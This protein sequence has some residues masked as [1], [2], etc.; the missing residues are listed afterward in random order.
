[1]VLANASLKP[2]KLLR[3][4]ETNHAHYKNRNK[5]FFLRK[6]HEFKENKKNI[7]SFTTEDK[8]Y[9][10]CS[11]LVAM[12][13]AKSKKAYTIGEKLLKPCMIDIF[14]ELFGSEYATKIN[15]IPMSNDT[16]S[17]RIN[18]MAVDIEYQLIQKIK[19]SIFYGIQIDE[20]TD[21]NNE[22]I[23]L[24]YIRYVDTDLN[25]I[26]EEFLCCLNLPSFC[27]SEEIFKAILMYFDKNDLSISK[28]IGIC[29]DGAAAM[30]RKFNGLVARIKQIAHK[31]IISTHCF[32]HREQLATKDMGENLFN[33]LN[34]CIK[35]INFIRSSAVNTRIFKVM[36][37]EMGSDYTSLLLHTHVRWLSRGKCLTRLFEL[38]T[39]VEIFLKDKK[40]PLGDYFENNLW[41]ANLA[42]LS[43]IFSILNDLN[44]SLQGSYTNI[45]TSNNKIEAFLNKIELWEKRSQ[46]LTFDMFPSF[47]NMV[48]EKIIN[49]NE[50]NEMQNVI[51]IHLLKL[52]EKFLKYFDPT[53]DIRLNNLWVINPFIK[54][55]K[56]KLSS[57]N[58]EKLIELYSDKGLEQIF[59][60]NKNISKFWIKIQ[61][62]YPALTEEALK[63][64]IPF[65]TTYLCEAGFS[66][67]TTIKTKSRNRLDISPTMRISL[68][69]SIE[70]RIDKIISNQQQQKSH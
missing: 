34:T 57:L 51:A 42:Y 52:K 10:K 28:C 25:D 1:M 70:P 40:S 67:M 22:A 6:L 33:V 65:S 38:K 32:I 14:T 61:S 41:L 50:I 60:S 58:E 26:N 63:K 18:I 37:D 2:N 62:E 29:T 15:S 20:S 36:C 19:K 49:E 27:T 13:I 21:I 7:K 54:S 56:N 59:H 35:I 3:H 23:L 44:L 55:E 24:I 17:R 45:F 9:L 39:E 16:I 53:T 48:E 43:D 46:K 31:D 47:F 12:H 64:L 8:K 69:K 11:Y 4:L 30:T 68:S 66:T 5:D